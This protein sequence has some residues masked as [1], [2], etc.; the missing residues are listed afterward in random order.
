MRETAVC[1]QLLINKSSLILIT[2][3]V[4]SLWKRG[5]KK[6]S[7]HYQRD[8]SMVLNENAES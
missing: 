7:I 5:L 2:K 1:T 6:I 8:T 3:L 4:I